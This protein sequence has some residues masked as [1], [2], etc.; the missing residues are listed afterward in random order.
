L[1]PVEYRGR[2]RLL[3]FK[4]E[5]EFTIMNRWPARSLTILA[6]LFLFLFAACTDSA[7]EQPTTQSGV[8][9]RSPT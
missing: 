9:Y 5:K 2:H 7:I 1:E 4:V 3:I 6:F 8:V